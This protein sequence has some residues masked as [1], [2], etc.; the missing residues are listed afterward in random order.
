MLI[1]GIDP[2]SI[3]TG[4][5]IVESFGNKVRYIDS[6]VLSFDSKTDFLTRLKEIKTKSDELFSRIKIDEVSIESLIF[7]K[8]PTALIK[9]AQTRGILLSSFVEAY[10]GSIYEYSPNEIKA[11]ATGYGHSDKE[12]IKKFLDMLLGPR[13]YKTHDESDALAIAVCHA[14]NRKFSRDSSK[15]MKKTKAKR[16]SRRGLADALA[17]KIQG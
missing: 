14:L 11:A 10:S 4:W 15:V 3:A 16:S 1:L 7:V 6:G 2:G 17:H 5:A 13:E 9:L 12:G 8:S